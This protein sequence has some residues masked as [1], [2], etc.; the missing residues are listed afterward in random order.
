MTNYYL[1][2]IL[3]KTYSQIHINTQGHCMR[4]DTNTYILTNSHKLIQPYTP[5]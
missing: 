5:F 4:N 2:M 1:I 3:H